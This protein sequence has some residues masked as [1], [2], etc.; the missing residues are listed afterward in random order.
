MLHTSLLITAGLSAAVA[1]IGMAAPTPA[2]LQ[3]GALGL[4]ALMIVMNYADRRSLVARLDLERDARDILVKSTLGSVSR[5][6]A[7]M[8]HRPCLAGDSVVE[9]IRRTI[10]DEMQSGK[11][12]SCVT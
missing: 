4:C 12:P 3:Y 7:V 9:E 1:A 8:E 2:W 11:P 10:R 5:L 6:A